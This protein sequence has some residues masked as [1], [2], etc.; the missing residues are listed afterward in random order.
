MF[1]P[2]QDG[3]FQILYMN[4]CLLNNLNGD[5]NHCLT[6][7]TQS[8]MLI[9]GHIRQLSNCSSATYCRSD[10]SVFNRDAR[11]GFMAIFCASL[12]ASKQVPLSAHPLSTSSAHCSLCYWGSLQPSIG[13]AAFGHLRWC[14]LLLGIRYDT[15]NSCVLFLFCCPQDGRRSLWTLVTV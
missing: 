4:S 13:G 10:L 3:K 7:L 9:A 8:Y 5:P 1:I 11:D 14:H 12:H 15:K 2:C 6:V